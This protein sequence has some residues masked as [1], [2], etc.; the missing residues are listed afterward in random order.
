MVHRVVV[1]L[2]VGALALSPGTLRA[3]PSGIAGRT[4]KSTTSGC[5]GSGCH[6]SSPAPSVTV[7]ISGPDSL[8]AGQS[9]VYTVSVTGASGAD[10][11]VDIAVRNGTLAIVSS[12][13]KIS[14][15]EAVHRQRVAVPSTYQV[16]YTAPA[17]PG[18]DTMYATGK[19]NGFNNWNHAPNKP[20]RVVTPTSVDAGS[21]FPDAPFL[22]Q[23]FPNPF[24]PGTEL[25]FV[26]PAAAEARLTVVDLTGREVALLLE[27]HRDA[28]EYRVAFDGSGLAS[29]V[30]LC[31]LRLRGT[32]GAWTTMTRK[33]V[34][35]K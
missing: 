2:A 18:V 7:S 14:S 15:G 3:I 32:E 23:N 22:Y 27:G 33:L 11:G 25:R 1:M 16:T 13:L 21:G 35:A 29:G 12:W 26:L 10:G 24:N 20:I 19:D 6:G 34:L 4:L 9:A 28:G 31:Q 8:V 30:Y 5:G 17:A